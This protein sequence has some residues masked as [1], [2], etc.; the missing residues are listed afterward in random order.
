MHRTSAEILNFIVITKASIT[1]VTFAF[2]LCFPS[3]RVV[4]KT[5]IPSKMLKDLVTKAIETET[6][7][8]RREVLEKG[9]KSKK[10]NIK[11]ISFLTRCVF[12]GQ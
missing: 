8:V 11:E 2:S 10:I 9:K 5:N 3:E 12:K 6:E 4:L 7:G 1:R